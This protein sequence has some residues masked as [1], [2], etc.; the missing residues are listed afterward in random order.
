MY[1]LAIIPIPL[2]FVLTLYLF[3]LQMGHY[4]GYCKH[5]FASKGVCIERFQEKMHFFIAVL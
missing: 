4:I 5:R 2:G 1:S 3:Y